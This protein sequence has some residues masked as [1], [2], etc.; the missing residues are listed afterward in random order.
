MKILKIYGVLCALLAINTSLI[1]QE[2]N[3]EEQ[4]DSIIIS[5]SRIHLPFKEN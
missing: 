1:A 3:K 5:S 4:L 2:S